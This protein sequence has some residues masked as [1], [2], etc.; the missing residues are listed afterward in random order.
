L[1]ADLLGKV[2]NAFF[3]PALNSRA[4]LSVFWGYKRLTLHQ[5]YNGVCMAAFSARLTGAT[6]HPVVNFSG[7]FIRVFGD[8]NA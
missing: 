3:Y 8:T 2:A 4:F 7:V 6:C 5:P 1:N